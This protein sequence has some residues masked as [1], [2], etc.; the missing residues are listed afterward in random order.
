MRDSLRGTNVIITGASRG[1]GRFLAQGFWEQGANLLVV[2]RSAAA[3]Y[4]LQ[5]SLGQTASASQQIHTVVTDLGNEQAVASIVSAAQ[6]YWG[7]IDVLVNNAA[8]LGPIGKAWEI[9]S[10]DWQATMQV[11]LLTPVALCQAVIPGMIRQRQ[12]KI[13]NLSGG[14]STGP[15]PY[16]SA[17]A[18]AKTGIVRFSEI[19]ALEVQ[20]HNIQVN[21]IAPGALPTEMAQA[22]LRAGPEQAGAKEYVQAG[23]QAKAGNDVIR[24]AVALSVFLASSESDGVTGKLISAVWDPWEQ[25]PQHLEDLQASDVYTLRRIVPE[26]RGLTWDKV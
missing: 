13:I 8:I 25:L 18:V 24:R 21:C 26:D 17:Y 6:R 4:E 9:S 3:L 11:N 22:V 23:K 14:G 20:E 12:G 2:A 1:L 5:E 16:F 19:L 10:A 7:S 15:R